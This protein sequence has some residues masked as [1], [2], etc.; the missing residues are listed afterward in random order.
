MA[1]RWRSGLCARWLG[2]VAIGMAV[3]VGAPERAA[4]QSAPPDAA[5]LAEAERLNKEV[6]LLSGQGQLDVAFA[7][8]V[9]A[10]AFNEK[11][12]G[13]EHLY[14]AVALSNLAGLYSAQGDYARALPLF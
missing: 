13:H 3:L 8:A 7:S 5:A 1:K 10:L 2:A 4:G 6:Y 14:V 11:A 12:L 9:R